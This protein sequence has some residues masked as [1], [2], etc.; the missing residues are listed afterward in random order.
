VSERSGWGLTG[1]TVRLGGA[2]ALDDVT[3]RADGG[4]VV[5]VVGGDGAGKST[6]LRTLAGVLRPAAGTVNRPPAARIGFL[7]A[8][9]GTYPDLTVRENLSFAA[10]AYQ[11]PAHRAGERIAD[12]LARTGLAAVSDRLAGR[13]SGGMRQKLGLIRAMLHEPDLLILDEPSTGV[14]PASRVD[15][16]WLIAQEAAR[17]CA[18]VVSTTYLDEAE[19]AAYVLVLDAGRRL[20]SGTP[21]DL[22][23]AV[24]GSLRAT[25]GRPATA[26]A[27]RRAG[28]WRSWHPDGGGDGPAVRPD[29]QDVVVLAELRREADR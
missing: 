27:W 22:L 21:D 5:A 1:V 25:P 23:Q 12:L 24:P 9:S 3:L 17:G 6:L 14:D 28:M 15:V 29:L 26:F 8:S 18:T 7:S 11:M 20:L 2:V 19:R 4:Q 16:W 13:L 10:A